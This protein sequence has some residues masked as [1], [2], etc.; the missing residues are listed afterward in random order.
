MSKTQEVL[1]AVLPQKAGA[2]QKRRRQL[3]HHRANIR[4][5]PSTRHNRRAPRTGPSSA[6]PATSSCALNVSQKHPPVPTE[7]TP[8]TSPE[9]SWILPTHLPAPHTA[10]LALPSSS[11]LVP[12]VG[13][14]FARL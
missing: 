2:R 13:I 6:P 1:D 9:T 10:S 14:Q 12:P 4:P 8:L 5:T 3:S 11:A 7:A